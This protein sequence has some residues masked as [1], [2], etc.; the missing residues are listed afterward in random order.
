VL[1]LALYI[2][3]VDVQV[4]YQYP[5]LIWVLCP[6]LLYWISRVWVVAVRRELTD[7]PLVWAVSD[8][9]SRWVFAIGAVVVVLAA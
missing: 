6:L 3:S 2:I 5:F 9:I 1:V 7:D 4:Q 8:Q